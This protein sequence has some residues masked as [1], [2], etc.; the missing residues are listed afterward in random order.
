MPTEDN[1]K[2]LTPRCICC[3]TRTTSEHEI[4][5]MDG[6]TAWRGNG[7]YGSRLIDDHHFDVEHIHE[8][9]VCDLCLLIYRNRVLVYPVKTV[10]GRKTYGPPTLWDPGVGK[11]DIRRRVLTVWEN[12]DGTFSSCDSDG[13]AAYYNGASN[14]LDQAFLRLQRDVLRGETNSTMESCRQSLEKGLADKPDAL[15]KRT[16]A[17]LD[18]L[19]R[20]YPMGRFWGSVR[21]NGYADHTGSQPVRVHNWT[22]HIE[23]RLSPGGW[24][25]LLIGEDWARVSEGV[26][27][28]IDCRIDLDKPESLEQVLLLMDPLKD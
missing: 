28:P 11:P 4:E 20:R 18:L 5:Q 27:D 17:I 25:V 9:H 26:S 8:I 10:E 23:A 22:A 2:G 14:A 19:E 24:T 13:G 3:G 6:A 16:E 12:E 1:P 15:R 7:N 21:D